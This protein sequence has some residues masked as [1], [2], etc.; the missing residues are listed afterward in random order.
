MVNQF[1]S[2]PLASTPTGAERARAHRHRTRPSTERR[3]SAAPHGHAPTPQSCRAASP[4][5]AACCHSPLQIR[6]R[7]RLLAELFP[8]AHQKVGSLLPRSLEHSI[9]VSSVVALIGADFSSPQAVSWDQLLAWLARHSG[10]DSDLVPN[11]ICIFSAPRLWI[12]P[13]SQFGELPRTALIWCP[14]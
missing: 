14:K 4:T 9:S 5:R 3:S 11:S 1:V 7:A 12:W 13:S 6:H 2:T 10:R 8:A